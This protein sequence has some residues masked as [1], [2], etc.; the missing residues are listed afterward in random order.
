MGTKRGWQAQDH[1][2]QRGSAG[3]MGCGYLSRG[4]V[5]CQGHLGQWVGDSHPDIQHL[6]AG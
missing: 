1:K 2:G 4:V 3:S 6:G 5:T